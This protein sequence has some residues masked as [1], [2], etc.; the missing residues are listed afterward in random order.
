MKKVVICSSPNTKSIP[1]YF[2]LLAN[3]FC[4]EGNDVVLVIDQKGKMNLTDYP[5]HPKLEIKSWPSYRPTRIVDYL[6]FYRLCSAFSPD[7][8]ISQFSSNSISLLVSGILPK[9]KA[10]VY[11]HTMQEQLL[12]D[13]RI[14]NLK[15]NLLK[16]RKKLLFRT[17]D[18][19]FLTNS[20]DLKEELKMLFPVKSK[21]ISILHYLMPDPLFKR[22]YKSFDQRE[23]AI[24]FVSRLEKSKGHQ[25]FIQEFAKVLPKF[26][27]LKLKIAGS[28]TEESPLKELV[29][30]LGIEENV[31]FLGECSYQEVLDLMDSTLVHVSNSS[32][33]AFGMVNVE[34]ISLGTPIIARKV[35]GIKE[36]LEPH[37]NGE[38]FDF[39]LPG[40][41]ECQ[42]TSVLDPNKWEEYSNQARLVF[43]TNFLASE[44]NL[45]NQVNF[46]LS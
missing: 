32:Q 35:G 3:Q 10:F 20:N 27:G 30:S 2:Y 1:L 17:V 46:L 31:S 37:R 43:E 8:I 22:S 12:S 19:E 36:I 28:G 34:A 11:W 38:F 45:N 21:R 25:S 16:I 44:T 26:N 4:K 9:A 14:S 13:L 40:N 33:E 41:L 39:N 5:P 7:L 23:Y 15:Y 29:K 24:S 18:F 42:L 6:F